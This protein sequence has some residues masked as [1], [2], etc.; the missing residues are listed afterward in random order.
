MHNWLEANPWVK[1]ALKIGK[2]EKIRVVREKCGFRLDTTTQDGGNS[3]NGPIADRYFDPNKSGS[4]MFNNQKYSWNRE[5]F[6]ILFAKYNIMLSLTQQVNSKKTVD[7]LKVK[8]VWY[9][10]MI[11]L[12]QSFDWTMITR[13]VH[14]MCACS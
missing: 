14:Q 9:D 10:F 2:E 4:H 5:T 1:D 11:F 8:E 13:S 12:R 6:S 3:N 7:P